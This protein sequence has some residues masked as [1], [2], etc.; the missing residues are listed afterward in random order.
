MQALQSELVIR[1]TEGTVVTRR[2][3]VGNIGFMALNEE[4]R[5]LVISVDPSAEYQRGGTYWESFDFSSRGFIDDAVAR[6]D[7]SPGGAALAYQRG[8]EIRIFDVA[9]NHSRHLAE[10]TLQA[11]SPNGKWIAFQSVHRRPEL[12]TPD[13][14]PVDWP[15]GRLHLACCLIWSP[16]GRFVSFHESLEIPLLFAYQTTVVC[17]VTDGACTSIPKAPTGLRWIVNYRSLLSGPDGAQPPIPNR[18]D[19]TP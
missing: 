7:W 16:D 13:G 6:A 15:L 17:R 14:V 12:V 18:G 19:H 11:W 3:F 9:T 10:G 1:T 2:R 4:A 5:R 8:S